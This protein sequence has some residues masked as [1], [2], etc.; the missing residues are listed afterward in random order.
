VY[1]KEI[2]ASFWIFGFSV[3]EGP[4]GVALAR[5]SAVLL[6]LSLSLDAESLDG[7]DWHRA[8]RRRH[9]H[10]RRGGT[11]ESFGFDLPTFVKTK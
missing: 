11:Q 2:R 7:S 8:R 3:W 10:R 6:L 9:F 5:D 4:Q 1:L